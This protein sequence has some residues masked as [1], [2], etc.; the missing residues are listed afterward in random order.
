MIIFNTTLSFAKNIKMGLME[1]IDAKWNES[2]NE[3]SF[4]YNSDVLM[5]SYSDKL[6][7]LNLNKLFRP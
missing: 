3:V 4:S 5:D 6:N 1:S 7:V 2:G